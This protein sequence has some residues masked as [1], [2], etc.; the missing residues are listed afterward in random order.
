MR[1]LVT[2]TQGQVAQSLAEA[3]AAAG[4]TIHLVGRP[5]FDLETGLGVEDAI[6]ASG[7]DVV[8]SAAAYTAV[9]K[10]ESEQDAAFAV[11]ASGAGRVAAAAA[12]AGIPVIHLSTDYVFSGS[13]DRPYVED[14]ETGPVS[15]YGASKLE[16]EQRV[17]AANPRH[18]ILRTAW[19]YSPFGSN[20]LRTML[21]LGETRAELGVVAD[22]QGT[23]TSA[24]D[25]AEAIL[26]VARRLKNAESPELYGTFH[27]TGSGEGNWADFADHI[28]AVAASHG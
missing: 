28:F 9:D 26:G 13:L 24:L 25:I 5:D 20:F 17:A 14:D 18:V 21:R 1:I 12:K 4:E 6:A 22:Q 19:V 16:G 10:A 8:V 3:G 23:P 15:I 2:G 11:N 27:L 7:A